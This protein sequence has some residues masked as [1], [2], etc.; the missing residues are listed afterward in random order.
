[1]NKL[2]SQRQYADRQLR[3]EEI[4]KKMLLDERNLPK[5]VRDSA[6]RALLSAFKFI[7]GQRRLNQKGSLYGVKNVGIGNGVSD[8]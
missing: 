6:K 7:S 5:S 3:L 4:K 8:I 1:V 2:Y